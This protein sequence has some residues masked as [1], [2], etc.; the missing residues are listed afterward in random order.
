MTL[1]DDSATHDNIV[2]SEPPGFLV[3]PGDET[4][5]HKLRKF[6]FA[7]P[8]VGNFPKVLRLLFVRKQTAVVASTSWQ[9]SCDAYLL[10]VQRVQIL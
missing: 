8:T 2:A 9:E 3:E 1:V 6:L 4:N 5:F 7:I 10:A